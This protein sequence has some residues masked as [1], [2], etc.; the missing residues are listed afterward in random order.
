MT[1]PHTILV[2]LRAAQFHGD[3]GIPAYLQSL[4]AELC[5]GYPDRRWLLLHDPARPQP[6][7]AADVAGLA[8][9]HTAAEL[10]GA[11]RRIDAV[12]TGCF[13]LPDRTATADSLLPGWLLDQAPRRLGIVYDLVPWLFPDRYLPDAG[14]KQRYA[15]CLRLLRGSD[16]LFGISR[17][18]CRD[19]VRHAAVDPARVHCIYGDIDHH[20]RALMER[21]AAETAAVPARHGLAGPYC[22]YVG[23][24][25]WRKNL[26]GMVR[27]FAHFHRSHSDHH[28]AIV[29]TI[30]PDRAEAIA[31]LA[32][33]LGLPP[34]A[35]VCTGYV[36]TEDLV[37]MMQQA[38]MMVYPSL[39]EGL[40]LP[41]LEAYGCNLPA[42]GSATSSVG[43]L[44]LP[45]LAFDP[46]DPVA[47]AAAMGRV[48]DEPDLAAASRAFGRRLLD[49]LGWQAAAAEVM[50]RLDGADQ[51][52]PQSAARRLA[53]VA[54]LPPAQTAIAPY[55]VRHLQ[56][57][58]WRTT[59]FDAN[60]GPS[61]ASPA[62]LRT[63]SKVL[64]VEVLR[65]VLDRSPPAAVIHVLGNSPH[66]AKVLE[67]MVRSRGA[68]VR[69][70][71]YLHEA[72]LTAA[73]R[74]WPGV[75]VKCLPQ[76]EPAADAAGW[77]RRALAA[78]PTMGRCL[79]FLAERA[80]LDGLIVN[81]AACRD[82]V[83]AAIGSLAHRWTI[84]VAMLP[85]ERYPDAAA[86]PVDDARPL[87]VGTFGIASDGKRL[88]CLADAVA[89]LARRRPARLLI[90][91]WR[92]AR[93]CRHTGI[94]RQ[95]WVEVHESPD[96][97]TLLGLMRQV[98]VAVQL[99]DTTHGESS[100]A[101]AHLLGLGRQVVVTGEGSFTE[102]P[103][104]LVTPV[105]VGCTPESLAAAIDTAA[106]RRPGAAAIEAALAPF[107][108]A[109]FEARLDAILAAA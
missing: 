8:T 109:A 80:D 79:R 91:G 82:L 2:D 46:A 56:P 95:R 27:G 83:R 33:D 62:G 78:A 22:L 54:A 9:W 15:A 36:S 43:E 48:V 4:V 42:V 87:V 20:K 40:G 89:L 5:R 68:G 38:T 97:E 86:P 58:A 12:L 19:T 74:T 76:A 1:P 50:R 35:V 10:A 96:D 90:A 108:P 7:R 28:L 45:E 64:P 57:A 37:G 71:A 55:T 49:G 102:L 23:G 98:H 105:P 51:P 92:A 13:F 69:R 70:L 29:C 18:T 63:S 106:R 17:A 81:S 103:P 31:R 52:R 44:V 41:V 93:Y 104:D 30:S 16:H 99:R 72:N 94:D 39:Y 73:F 21:P 25:D 14:S 26:E 66:H 88:D 32:A 6:T 77:I 53:V 65:S 60:R 75:D 84:D 67:A 59:F 11:G 107:S 34:R 3:R 61:I 101:V 100:G 85:I 47:L 24:D